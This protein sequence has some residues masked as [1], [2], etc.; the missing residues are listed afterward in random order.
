M[1][2]ERGESETENFYR[3]QESATSSSYASPA[4]RSHL[5]PQPRQLQHQQP[6][7][8][9]LP[10]PRQPQPV[11]LPE[12]KVVNVKEPPKSYDSSFYCIHTSIEIVVVVSLVSLQRE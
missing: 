9:Q 1:V 12:Y 2:G 11:Q 7:E 10:E 6:R 3:Q 5:Q 4:H 8:N